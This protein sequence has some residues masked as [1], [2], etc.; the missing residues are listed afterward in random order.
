[1]FVS[2]VGALNAAKKNPWV[3]QARKWPQ[4]DK[5]LPEPVKDETIGPN[6]RRAGEPKIGK[7]KDADPLAELRKEILGE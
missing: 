5:D 7:P 2:S 1:M 6:V 3:H 4:K